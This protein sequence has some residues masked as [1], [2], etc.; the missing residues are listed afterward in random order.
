MQTTTTPPP[1]RKSV[2]VNL[3]KDL[4]R[5]LDRRKLIEDRSR[6]NLIIRGLRHYLQTNSIKN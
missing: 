1:E 3:P 4:I 2:L 5:E 6:N